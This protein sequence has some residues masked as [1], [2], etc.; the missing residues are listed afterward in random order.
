[1]KKQTKVTLKPVV[2]C[3]GISVVRWY[4]SKYTSGQLIQRQVQDA[5]VDKAPSMSTAA[6]LPRLF[7]K[8]KP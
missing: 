1:M 4:A 3:D 2:T 6:F 5:Q 7:P 8:K